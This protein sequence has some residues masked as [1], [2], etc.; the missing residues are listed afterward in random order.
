[1]TLFD[2]AK[3][4]IIGNF[5][6]YLVYFVS[7]LFS[8][9][10]Y[11]TFVSLQYSSQIAKS[12]ESSES[13]QSIFLISSMILLLFVAVFILYSNN[14]FAKKR[15]KEI[16]LY[17][18][19]GLPRKTIG[20]ML[21]YENLIMGS[22]VLITG[23]AIGTFLSKLFT[24]ILLK[25][26]DVAVNTGI[27]FSIKAIANTTIVFTTIILFT[28]IQGYRLIYKFKLIELFHAEKKGEQEPGA[29]IGS[30]ILS[31]LFLVLG[32]WAA[33]QNLSTSEEV[34]KN[35]GMMVVGITLGTV[36][37]FSS[38]VVVLLKM[39]KRSKRNY[40]K[41][42]NLVIL[43]NLIYRIKGNSRTLCVISL[44][45][46]AT[47]C[48]FSVGF[49]MYYGFEETSR[50]AAPFSYMYISQ[51]DEFNHKV[52]S[53]IRN[54]QEHPV[55]TQIEIPVV[56]SKAKSSNKKILSERE[57]KADENPVKVISIDNYNQVAKV[58][59]LPELEPMENGKAI[60]IRPMYTDLEL[61]DYKGET[62]TFPMKKDELTFEFA[63]MTTERVIN[64]SY[65]DV[66]V[67]VNGD[68]YE[69]LKDQVEAVNYVG[70]VVQDQKTAKKTAN[71]LASIKTPESN[72]STFY[73]EYRLGIEEA[74]FNI[75]ILGFLG[76]VFILATGS[77]IYF[78]QLTEAAED[79]TRYEILKKVGVSYKEIYSSIFKQNAFIFILPLIVGLTHY[80]IILNLLKR[81]FS[82]M[83]G[84]NL[85]LPVLICVAIFIMIYAIY[86]VLTVNSIGRMVIGESTRIIRIAVVIITM[87]VI[88]LIGMFI[89]SGE[90]T[91]VEQADIGEKIHLDLPEPTGQ[92]KVGT[93]EM[94]L[95]D[96]HRTDPWMD[97][98]TRELMISVWYPAQ[99]KSKQKALYMQPGTA[100]HYDVNTIPT[101]G[102]DP[103]RIDFTGIGLNAW[104]NAPVAFHEKGWP[105]ILYSP[106]MGV[107]RNFSTVLVEELASR[108]YVVVTADHTYETSAVQFPDGRVVTQKLPKLSAEVVLKAID[109]RVEDMQYIL[110]Q[111]AALQ[112]G[113]N[114]DHKQRKLPPGIEKA[115][116]LSRVGIFGHSAGGATSA[117]L[118]YEDNRV[119]AGINMDGTLGYMPNDPLPVAK[120]GLNRP[121][122]LMN[123]GY[124]DDGE[125]DSHL[126]AEDRRSFWENSGGWKLD[127]SV[128]EGAHFTFT[129]YVA[130]LPQLEHKFS[131]SQQVIQ[132][133]I[134]TI[135]P[136]QMI[137][138]QR[139]YI[140]AFFD[141]HLKGIPQP[142]LDES[143]PYPD[144]DV[145]K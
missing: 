118:M 142:L 115:F 38:M 86:Y 83:V 39:G 135:N 16:G 23:I 63:G 102:L 114:P 71:A 95:V 1:M 56:K 30:T 130:L 47:L 133:S 43:S 14:F 21:F 27:T 117:Q 25:L 113:I 18:L 145:M 129:D 141:L 103:G 46:A 87:C 107:P 3:K 127:I 17:A 15:K 57:I 84:I 76:L 125:A 74:A 106:G 116:D 119:D 41:G 121:F 33:F 58:L 73:S 89:W 77:I 49:A 75:F 68:S 69:K 26:L 60:A 124:N 40:Y 94:H 97:N 144:V 72:L 100:K 12:I 9:V 2:L 85:V 48:A 138:A 5:K 59:H 28:S 10:I 140:A 90:P 64:W 93:T 105:V 7:M 82:A 108:G 65:P 101:I 123:A 44:L 134:G 50:L 92:Y 36:L 112:K 99:E 34:L 111:L 32:Y 122:M 8:V 91:S 88:A 42:M 143:A 11:Y 79:Q 131:I 61:S 104:Q 51:N 136:N 24:M 132:K 137:S 19:L 67:V 55:V 29:S 13:M 52:D 98:K 139:N 53:I 128:P 109:A 37:L 54:D 96:N 78:K 6:N 66:M 70:Y 4:N 110:D 31:V 80:V 62:I 120:Y 35:T 22:I 81:L 126:T 45:S 20:K